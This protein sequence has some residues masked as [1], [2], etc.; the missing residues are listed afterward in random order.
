[1][2]NLAVN[3]DNQ[4]RRPD[5]GHSVVMWPNWVAEVFV[6]LG[7]NRMCCLFWW[8]VFGWWRRCVVFGFSSCGGDAALFDFYFCVILVCM[9]VLIVLFVLS[10]VLVVVPEVVIRLTCAFF[11]LFIY[12]GIIF[13]FMFWLLCLFI[14]LII[15]LIYLFSLMYFSNYF[16]YLF[17]KLYIFSFGYFH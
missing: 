7:D 6:F 16:I 10:S 9:R 1:M 14:H 5:G 8:D 15:L 11:Y 4:V 3:A 17:F 2:W 12:L 13:F